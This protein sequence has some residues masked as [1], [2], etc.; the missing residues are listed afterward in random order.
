MGKIWKG[1]AN[2]GK[3]GYVNDT[4][5]TFVPDHPRPKVVFTQSEQ[6]RNLGIQ[7]NGL[8]GVSAFDARDAGTTR[9]HKCQ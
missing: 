3:G 8:A 4:Q 9:G 5:K 2:E 6:N 1:W 7:E